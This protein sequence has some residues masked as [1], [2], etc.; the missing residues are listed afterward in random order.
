MRRIFLTLASAAMLV[1]SVD[2][3]ARIR[4]EKGP[5]AEI[6]SQW[7]GRRVAFLGDSITD[8]SQVER[9]VNDTY[10]YFLKD[11]LG[12]EPLVYG[13]NGHQMSHIVGQAQKMEDEIGQDLDAI[14]VFAGTNDYNESVP[15]GEWYNYGMA[16]ATVNGPAEVLRVHR[17]FNMDETTFRGRVNAVLMHLKT[18]Y[19]DKQIMLLTPIHRSDAYF[20]PKNIQPDESFANAAG[21]FID[22]Y[23]N[24]IK[25]ASDVWSVPVIDIFALSGLMPSLEEHHRYFRDNGGHDY[26]HPNTE[27]HRRMAYAIAYQLLSYPSAF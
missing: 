7:L 12:I 8:K 1:A 26:L 10:W 21:L 17:E 23:V 2:L 24:V 25:E 16:T 14:M 9:G 11:I 3:D 20:G 19:P 27:G 18:T 4:P 6:Q 22:D 15:L 5:A 13:I